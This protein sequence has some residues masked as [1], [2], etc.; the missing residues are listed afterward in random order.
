M[1]DSEKIEQQKINLEAVQ[2]LKEAQAELK[3]IQENKTMTAEDFMRLS[4]AVQRA[5]TKL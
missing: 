4:N 2:F 1:Q 5:I 3:K